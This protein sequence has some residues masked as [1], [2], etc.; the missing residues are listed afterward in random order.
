MIKEF[1]LCFLYLYIVFILR[2]RI[3]DFYIVFKIFNFVVVSLLFIKKNKCL[4]FNVIIFI[5]LL[6][7][8]VIKILVGYLIF[9]LIG[10]NVIS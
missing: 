7:K 5:I 10:L 9:G 1:F 8:Y 4:N 2:E 6:N 3:S